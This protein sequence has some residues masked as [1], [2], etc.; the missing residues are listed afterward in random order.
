MS[1]I[2]DK[3]KEISDRMNEHITT[4]KGTLEVLDASVSEDDLRSL[5]LKSIE[6][7]EKIQG[8]AD[9]IFAALRQALEKVSESKGSKEA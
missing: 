3:L 1:E 6:R 8:L 2:D 9:E 4:V 7:M 5:I